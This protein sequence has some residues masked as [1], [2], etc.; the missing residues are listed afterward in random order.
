MKAWERPNITYD[1][2]GLPIVTPKARITSGIGLGFYDARP[3]VIAACAG[4]AS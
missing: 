1:R 3:E 4:R 2:N